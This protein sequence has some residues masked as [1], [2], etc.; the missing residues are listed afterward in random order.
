MEND[1]SSLEDAST[2]V[3]VCTSPLPDRG[4]GGDRRG[5]RKQVWFTALLVH[6]TGGEGG[7]VSTS[8]GLE[9]GTDCSHCWADPRAEEVET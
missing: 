4:T 3:S 5:G 7:S 9:P 8:D 6:R 1:S 2:N